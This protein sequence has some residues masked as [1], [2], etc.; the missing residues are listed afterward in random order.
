LSFNFCSQI[1]GFYIIPP[2]LGSVSSNPLL[3][4]WFVNSLKVFCSHI[5]K[6]ILSFS[7]IDHVVLL[8]VSTGLAVFHILY[9]DSVNKKLHE[10]RRENEYLRTDIMRI[11]LIITNGQN[12]N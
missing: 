3:N 8:Y 4:Y 11:T 7:A 12:T 1:T 10:N 9:S 2:V 5:F 6:I